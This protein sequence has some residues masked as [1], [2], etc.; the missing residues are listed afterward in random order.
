MKRLSLAVGLAALL[1]TGAL[2]QSSQGQ[3]AGQSG[4]NGNS[5][6][7]D[8]GMTNS[9]ARN[10]TTGMGGSERGSP[11]GSPSSAP[12]ATTGPSAQPSNNEAPPK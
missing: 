9:G 7:I 10:G 1:S 4:V 6:T 2:A 3:A 11:N 5:S 8:S 12:K